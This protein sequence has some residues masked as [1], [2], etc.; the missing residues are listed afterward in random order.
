MEEFKE[1]ISLRCVFCR[2]TLFAMPH[3]GYRPHHGSFVVCANCGHENDY[4]SLFFVVKDKAMDIAH[5]YAERLL[6]KA[7]NDMKKQLQNAFRGNKY[8][9][10]C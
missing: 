5:E 8:I 2:S 6:E 9:K 10:I 3:E 7:A 1:I 4:T